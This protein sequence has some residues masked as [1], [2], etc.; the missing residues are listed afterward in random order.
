MR[1]HA[2]KCM[3]LRISRVS[4]SRDTGKGF[5]LVVRKVSH[6]AVRNF[7]HHVLRGTRVPPGVAF[8]MTV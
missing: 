5:L 7:P 8:Y 1:A 2:Y 6:L 4:W 3:D